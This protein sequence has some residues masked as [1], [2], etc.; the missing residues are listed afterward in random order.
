MT[1]GCKEG[2]AAKK[3][4]KK[5]EA[6]I[7]AIYTRLSQGDF[8]D[9]QKLWLHGQLSAHFCLTREM[10]IFRPIQLAPVKGDK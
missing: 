6:E 1:P 9:G 2:C 8:T 4:L 10:K 3:D 7:E 5:R